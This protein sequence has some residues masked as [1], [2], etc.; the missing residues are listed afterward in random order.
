MDQQSD[1]VREVMGMTRDRSASRGS[2]RY[3]NGRAISVTGMV[4]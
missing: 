4:C 1:R 3:E 2:S